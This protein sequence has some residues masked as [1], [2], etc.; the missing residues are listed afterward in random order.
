MTG[1][2]TGPGTELGRL[3][4]DRPWLGA[5]S[6]ALLAT[7]WLAWGLAYPVMGFAMAMVDPLTLRTAVMALAGVLLLCYAAATAKRLLVPR[8]LWRDLAISA[9]GNMTVCQM[10][11]TFGV[12]YVGAGR[13]SVLIYTM[14]LWAAL[15]G[16]LLLGDPI[17]VRR[18]LALALGALSVAALLAQHLPQVRNAPLGVLANLIAAIGFGFGTVWTKRTSWPLDLTAM[19]GW[20]LLVGAVPLALVWLVVQPPLDLARLD[21]THWVAVAYMALI[22]NA[23]AYLVW[24]RLV[25]RLPTAIAGIGSLVVPCVGVL[26]STV[27]VDEAIRPTDLI[28]LGLVCSAL[29]LVL[30]EPRRKLPQPRNI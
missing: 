13:S 7:L 15:F 3:A 10:G 14:P 8:A 12:Y 25:R 6:L 2:A 26:S 24:F 4:A 29:V 11:M 22:G 30:F 28:A 5:G 18:G 16:R 19:A 27:L 9:F 1:P 23:L 21:A 17:T 20:Q